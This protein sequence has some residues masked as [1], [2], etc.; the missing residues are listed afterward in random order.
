MTHRI[1]RPVII[2]VLCLFKI[3]LNINLY[4]LLYSRFSFSKGMNED[5]E[6]TTI[7]V[8]N[9]T[10]SVTAQDLYA[11]FS[12]FGEIKGV[13]IPRDHSTR[14]LQFYSEKFRGFAFVEFDER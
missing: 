3:K 11:Y 7:Y 12:T 10:E 8:G 5:D 2:A 14:T 6:K 4:S 13:E 9:L 1:G